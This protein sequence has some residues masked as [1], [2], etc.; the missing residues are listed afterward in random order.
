[1]LLLSGRCIYIYT[2]RHGNS[3]QCVFTSKYI[4]ANTILSLRVIDFC[5]GIPIPIKNEK[6]KSAEK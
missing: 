3:V 1:M 4:H 2:N 6:K 5:L